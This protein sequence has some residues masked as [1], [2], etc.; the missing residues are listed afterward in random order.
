[1]SA[2][3]DVEHVFLRR[4]LAGIGITNPSA[5][6]LDLYAHDLS[7]RRRT[8]AQYGAAAQHAAG[9][10]RS[11]APVVREEPGAGGAGGD[12]AG[13]ASD[14]SARRRRVRAPGCI[15]PSSKSR[16]VLASAPWVPV[17]KSNRHK[18]HQEYQECWKRDEAF[19]KQEKRRAVEDVKYKMGTPSVVLREND[20]VGTHQQFMEYWKGQTFIDAMLYAKSR[21]DVVWRKRCELAHPH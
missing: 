6:S 1:M 16:H 17:S 12:D 7:E 19:L 20:P 8:M 13:A 4:V 21:D 2:G 3:H 10:P 5:E 14:R 15:I 18:R 9:T 11:S